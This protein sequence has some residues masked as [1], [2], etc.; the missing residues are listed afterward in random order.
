MAKSRTSTIKLYGEIFDWGMNSAKALVDQ[1]VQAGHTSDQIDMHV[2]CYG[3]SVTEG[4]VLYNAIKNS[5]APIDAYIDGVAASMA[6]IVLMAARKIYISENALL[7]LHAPSGATNGRGTASEHRQTLRA[8]DAMEATFVK[9]LVARTSKSEREVKEWLN[10]DTW[11]SAD[12]A[13]AVGLVDGIVDPIAPAI[14]SLSTQEARQSGIES[15][16]SLY[17][18]HLSST[19][20]IQNH[21]QMN[22]E[23]IIATLCLAGV[24]AQSSDEELMQA[25]TA[26]MNAE[27][28]ARKKA[29]TD[30]AALMSSEIS[31]M[32][33][34]VKDKVTLEKREQLKAI[35]Q[36]MGVATLKTAIEPYLQ[37]KPFSALI[38]ANAEGKSDNAASASWTFDEWQKNDAAGLERLAK[39]NPE[40]FGALYKARFGVEAPK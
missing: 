15:V 8:L 1:I 23:L 2:H 36:T 22:K 20:N 33:D 30:L 17:S 24:T 21:K 9:T 37:I 10:G 29:E 32:L 13:L 14:T 25:I 7:M 34:S 19:P 26:K 28:T 27:S 38:G 6:P 4:L 12:E 18:A 5:A 35:G 11:F 31:A 3:G 16:Y 39:E 40:S